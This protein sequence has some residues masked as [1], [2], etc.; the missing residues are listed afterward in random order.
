MFHP[1]AFMPLGQKQELIHRFAALRHLQQDSFPTDTAAA[2]PGRLDLSLRSA[3]AQELR[4]LLMK[5]AG[6]GFTQLILMHL[7]RASLQS[8][9]L[10]VASSQKH[11]DDQLGQ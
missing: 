10:A 3:E 7:R 5:L 6:N 2:I 4:D 1:E 9:P 11:F 8:S